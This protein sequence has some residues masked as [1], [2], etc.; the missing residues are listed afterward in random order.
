MLELGPLAFAQPWVL[1]ALASLPLLWWLLRVTP[2]APRL[3]R[4]PAIRLL[5]GLQPPEETPE[6]AAFLEITELRSDSDP[7]SLFNGW[8][9]ASSPA[10]SAVEHP[11]YDVWVIDCK[12]A[13]SSEAVNSEGN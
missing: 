3:L 12:K 6:S 10:L 1:A 2:P 8:M 7:V 9:F 13:S 11:V 4:F 5:F